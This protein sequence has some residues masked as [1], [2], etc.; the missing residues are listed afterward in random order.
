[1]SN[2]YIFDYFINL[3]YTT[4]TDYE[5]KNI[6][7][8]EL[9][10]MH[11]NIKRDEHTPEN[12]TAN[13]TAADIEKSYLFGV[14][15]LQSG[16]IALSIKIFEDCLE[17][18]KKYNIKA[19]DANIYYELSLAYFSLFEQDRE[20]NNWE[21]SMDYC[22][23]AMETALANPYITQKAGFMIYK[24]ESPLAYIH[25]LIHL[26]VLHQAKED[27][28]KALD[29]LL[30][31]KTICQHYCLF[32]LLGTVCDELGTTYMMLENYAFARYYYLKSMQIKSHINNQNGS[33]ITLHKLLV[34]SA[35][36]PHP[37]IED[38]IRRLHNVISKER[39]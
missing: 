16:K 30:V 10:K 19:N 28:E 35:L 36:D 11:N 32:Q 8:Q 25:I 38:E 3:P 6:M 14:K 1:M 15:V 31:A 22:K 27:Y 24:E 18:S 20:Q 29:L 5:G 4:N 33:A 34:L 9:E 12:E 2:S 21:K 7:S 13:N 37:Q 26:G 17:R 39:I 23:K